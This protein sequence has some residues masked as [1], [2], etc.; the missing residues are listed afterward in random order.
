MLSL[1]SC[2]LDVPGRRDTGGMN[3][4]VHQLAR[5]LAKQGIA[6]DIFTSSHG[7]T[8]AGKGVLR[9]Q[10]RLIHL[11]VNY[12]GGKLGLYRH[13]P[14][15]TAAINRFAR[16]EGTGYRLVHSHYWLSGLAGMELADQW[17]V[18]HITMLHT[19][20]RAKNHYLGPGTESELRE[21]AE[22]KILAAADLVV[23]STA[24]EKEDL[25]GMY[26]AQERKIAVIP[27]GVDLEMFR[28]YPKLVA[29]KALGLN[30]Q[31]VV[32]YVGRIEPEKGID[33]LLEAQAI[34]PAGHQNTRLMIV[35]GDEA[36]GRELGKL[37]HISAKLGIAARVVF[38][39]AVAQARL[40]F[41]Y[42][43]ADV[44]VLPSR[45]E[46]FG[47]VALESLA[48]GTPVIASRVG[49]MEDVIQ[50]GRNGFLLDTLSPESVASL[51]SQLLWDNSLRQ[52]MS[53]SARDTVQYYAWSG[54]AEKVARQYKRLLKNLKS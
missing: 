45:Y 48:C 1:H 47:M 29:R 13:L 38:Q 41:F 11:P 6:V 8:S 39:G 51:Q 33:L 15:L 30:G 19:S 28:P 50:P 54:I 35:G 4:Y 7:C 31:P 49:A 17:K 16:E 5:S 40:P 53:E 27:C 52:K 25:Q 24:R 14:E 26:G 20:G 32:L 43:S 18:P 12:H 34:S 36:E 3:V 23:A 37:R 10:V 22:E 9:D 46:T 42:S 2:P 44:C 21:K